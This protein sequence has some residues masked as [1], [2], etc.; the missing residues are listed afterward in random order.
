MYVHVYMCTCIN[1]LNYLQNSSGVINLTIIS[2]P[3]YLVIPS[4]VKHSS[5][6]K[7]TPIHVI[8]RRRKYYCSIYYACDDHVISQVMMRS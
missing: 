1:E 8:L 4:K 3:G 2:G 7:G 6:V 5:S